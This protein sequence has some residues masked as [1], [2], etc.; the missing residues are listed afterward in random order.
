MNDTTIPADVFEDD[1]PL[2]WDV[3]NRLIAERDAIA[4]A[5]LSVD[6]AEQSGTREAQCEALV[7]LSD[8]WLAVGAL[9]PSLS[10]ARRALAALPTSIVAIE[11]AASLLTRA[12][13]HSDAAELHEQ[14]AALGVTAAWRAAAESFV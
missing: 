2:P 8:A 9:N 1:R 10:A 3:A 14:R 4:V 7:Q 13:S 12:G 6:R 5:E 11:R